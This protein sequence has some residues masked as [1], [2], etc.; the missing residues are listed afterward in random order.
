MN[1]IVSLS[2][3][4]DFNTMIYKITSISLEHTIMKDSECSIK[5]DLIVSGTYKQSIASQNDSPFSY[6]V[7]VDIVLDEK[8]DLDNITI[9]IDDF[10][11][12][13]NDDNKLKINVDLLLNNIIKKEKIIN[14]EK[15]NEEKTNEEKTDDELVK[16]DDLFLDK[17]EEK[18][19]NVDKE[20]LEVLD[21]ND[22]SKN[23]DNKASLF[24]NLD[25]SNESYSTYSVYIMREND[26]IDEI[27]NKY[28]IS[29]EKLGEYND[30]D[31]I[32]IGSKIIIPSDE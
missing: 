4:I 10:T 15:T 13:V 6:K 32:K 3:N 20:Q 29:R 19:L 18:K 17:S 30:L 8:Y 24:L 26:S 14:E 7:P 2:K 23:N 28:N 5:G 25:S 22:D 11:Y 12:E 31:N 9:D 1:E 27:I 21:L 16:L